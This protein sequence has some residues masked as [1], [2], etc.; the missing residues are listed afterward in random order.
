MKDNK[1]LFNENKKIPILLNNI[2]RKFFIAITFLCLLGIIIFINVILPNCVSYDNNKLDIL[3]NRLNENLNRA[4]ILKNTE[5]IKSKKINSV[6][7]L[8]IPID[9]E[10]EFKN[11][12]QSIDF[13]VINKYVSRFNIKDNLKKP[14]IYKHINIWLL[15]YYNKDSTLNINK[16]KYNI[17]YKQLKYIL[18]N[19]N[20]LILFNSYISI[21]KLYIS[22]DIENKNLYY[23]LIKL[24]SNYAV[25][26]VLDIGALNVI[27]SIENEYTDNKIN[28]E[29]LY[30]NPDLNK[31]IFALSKNNININIFNDILIYQ[32]YFDL[33]GYS[34]I[35]LNKVNY[36]SY[37]YYIFLYN[38]VKNLKVFNVRY[39][40]YIFIIYF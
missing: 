23:N 16:N 11:Y 18:N 30:Y 22:T 1:L 3:S 35:L 34:D 5:Y 14:F 40:Y 10:L 9:L 36:K 7:N 6:K 26:E 19:S 21:K 13:N 17:F 29:Y 28:N 12:K 38:T 25:E 24:N 15:E 31:Y 4:Y 8:L 32:Y 2:P 33:V 27:I 37:I 20:N 39:F